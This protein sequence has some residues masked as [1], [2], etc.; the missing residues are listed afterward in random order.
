MKYLLDLFSNQKAN[1]WNYAVKNDSCG[2]G[3]R[4]ND[5]DDDVKLLIAFGKKPFACLATLH[6]LSL[7][8]N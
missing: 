5:G 8:N 2:Y 7:L 6:S 1:D 3:M 4:D